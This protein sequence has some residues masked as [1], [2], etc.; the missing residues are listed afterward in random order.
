M[1][2]FVVACRDAT[3]IFRFKI[4]A[5]IFL[6]FNRSTINWCDRSTTGAVI[7]N[8]YYKQCHFLVTTQLNKSTISRVF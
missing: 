3:V 6:N 4:K 1:T 7:V 8:N 5:I 2:W